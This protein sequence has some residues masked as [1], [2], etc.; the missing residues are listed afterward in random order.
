MRTPPWSVTGYALLEAMAV[1]ILPGCERT[2]AREES[3]D[4][5]HIAEIR[6]S[7]ALT[8]AKDEPLSTYVDPHSRFSI[9]LP[10]GW[11]SAPDLPGIQFRDPASGATLRLTHAPDFEDAI[12]SARRDKNIIA[13]GNRPEEYR[14]LAQTASGDRLRIRILATKTGAAV[15]E[16]HYPAHYGNPLLDATA[17][18]ALASLVTQ[19]PAP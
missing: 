17:E 1:A 5:A 11:N 19:A 12:K 14:A 10:A 16:I 9:A 4:L 13:Q 7:A 6:G 3:A 2:S 8:P 15:A 18:L